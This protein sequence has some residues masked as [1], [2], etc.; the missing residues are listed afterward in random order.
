MVVGVGGGCWLLLVVGG[1]LGFLSLV[2]VGGSLLVVGGSLL[3]V[4]GLLVGVGGG[5]W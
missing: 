5:C 4:G 2:V 1:F 3:V